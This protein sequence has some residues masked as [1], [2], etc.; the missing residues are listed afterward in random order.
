MDTERSLQPQICDRFIC[1]VDIPEGAPDPDIVVSKG[2]VSNDNT[3]GQE[4]K[5]PD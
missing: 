3:G 5:G 2:S 4:E 1:A